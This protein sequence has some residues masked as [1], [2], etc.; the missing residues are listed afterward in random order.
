MRIAKISRR[1]N[2]CKPYNASYCLAFRSIIP[3]LELLLD[4]GVA[5]ISF[6][7]LICEEGNSLAL[8]H[9]KYLVACE[10]IAS[11]DEKFAMASS[12]KFQTGL[13]SFPEFGYSSVHTSLPPT[14]PHPATP[15]WKRNL[16]HKYAPEK[17]FVGPAE[18]KVFANTLGYA[19]VAYEEITN[20]LSS[21]NDLADLAD[22]MLE[23]FHNWNEKC[24]MWEMHRTSQ[25]EGVIWEDDLL[26]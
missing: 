6:I 12:H 24:E 25:P 4:A 14:P 5:L 13:S 9:P 20:T 21:I 26:D 22:E 15:T 18:L 10:Q 1:L 3:R 2:K 23:V 7:S 11:G 8:D 19:H 16:A 17:L